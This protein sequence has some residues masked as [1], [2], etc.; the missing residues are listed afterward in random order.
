MSMVKQGSNWV[1][2]ASGGVLIHPGDQVAKA[3]ESEAPAEA[4]TKAVNTGKH[5]WY[6]N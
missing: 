3:R 6:W 2:S 4:R 5:G 1:I